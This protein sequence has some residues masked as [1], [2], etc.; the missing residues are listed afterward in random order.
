M[1][2]WLSGLRF[3]DY[4]I[5]L[6]LAHLFGGTLT[7][8]RSDEMS[9]KWAYDLSNSEL[10]GKLVNV[11][12]RAGISGSGLVIDCGSQSY[13]SDL[14]YLKGVVL[15]R[16]EGKKPP[17]KTG[18]RVF[19]VEGKTVT[20]KCLS[21]Y[22]RDWWPKDYVFNDSAEVVGIIYL[23]NDEWEI[24]LKGFCSDFDDGDR[25][26]KGGGPPVRFNAKEFVLAEQ[27]AVG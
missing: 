8:E 27:S 10:L 18:D 14:R 26:Q 22:G 16:L 25:F 11:A 2:P 24:C 20:G 13:F 7:A 6:V 15:A 19:P 9:A 21:T 1:S 3:L 5:K 4:C 12:A 17:F 23:G